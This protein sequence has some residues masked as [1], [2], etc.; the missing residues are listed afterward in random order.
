MAVPELEKA[1]AEA[2]ARG[3]K[4][5]VMKII[6]AIKE[7]DEATKAAGMDRT[8]AG[9]RQNQAGATGPSY[10]KDVTKGGLA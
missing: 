9:I 10:L 6:S 7:I 8:V 4:E 3:D 5:E 1:L 2:D